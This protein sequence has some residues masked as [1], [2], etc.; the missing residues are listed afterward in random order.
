MSEVPAFQQ[1]DLLNDEVY[2]LDCFSKMYIW[3][4]P[5]SNKFEYAGAHKKTQQY[6][7]DILDNRVKESVE[8]VDVHAGCEP[9][10]FKVQFQKWSD[11]YAEHHW[12][13]E[14][15]KAQQ[16]TEESKGSNNEFEGFLDPATH[17]FAYSELVGQQWPEG[18]K[19]TKKEAYLSDQEF[20]VV[21]KMPRA[22]FITLKE[23]K[24]TDLKK[25]VKLF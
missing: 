20:E 8:I 24:Q 7:K 3:I 23:W 16:K 12:K 19:H 9:P 21:F 14:T 6:I 25:P 10:M 1:Q 5:K 13:T 18:V 11:S 15:P 22:K 17:K 2:V 4:G